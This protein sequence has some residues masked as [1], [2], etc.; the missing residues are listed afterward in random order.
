[1]NKNINMNLEYLLDKHILVKPRTFNPSIIFDLKNNKYSNKIN[2]HDI[3]Y[4]TLSYRS[5]DYDPCSTSKICIKTNNTIEYDDVNNKIK[6][7]FSENNNFFGANDENLEDARFTIIHDKLHLIYSLANGKVMQY[8]TP[9]SNENEK[10][11]ILKGIELNNWEKNWVI[12]N[13]SN[14]KSTFI[15][16]S[17]YPTFVVYELD[18]FSNLT[19]IKSCDFPYSI[20]GRVAGGTS[21]IEINNKLYLF[22]HYRPSDAPEWKP[23]YNLSLV[24]LDN[25]TL[26][27]IGFCKDL[28]EPIKIAN[29]IIFCRG[30]LYIENLETFILSLGIDDYDIKLINL[31]LK[32][33]NSKLTFI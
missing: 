29:N 8:L 16:Y 1:M 9:Y 6:I 15:I 14:S 22:C 20:S 24:V 25:E 28:L 31:D 7:K 18:E 4:F 17:F 30:A 23:I 12:F 2:L 26:E 11:E 13:K 33:V 19:K 32:N 27:I 3:A 5:C 21:P 10:I